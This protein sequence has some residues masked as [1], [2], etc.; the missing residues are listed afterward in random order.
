MDDVDSL[1]VAA[2]NHPQMLDRAMFRR[3]DAVIEYPLPTVDVIKSLIKN[4]LANMRVGKRV[5]W[6]QVSS[7]AKG[8]SHSEIT[9]AAE[10]AAKD[11]ILA[12]RT[13]VET[14]D[15]VAALRE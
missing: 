10:L 8:L 11:V 1:L 3:F 6:T 7:A 15:L 12:K 5:A 2:T 13:S 9:L 14:S 4:R